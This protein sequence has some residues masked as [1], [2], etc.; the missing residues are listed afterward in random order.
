M[1]HLENAGLPGRLPLCQRDWH[2]H[3][4]RVVKEDPEAHPENTVRDGRLYHHILHWLDFNDTNPGD[5]W[6]LRIPRFE[7]GNVLRE[8]HDEPRAGHLGSAETLVRLARQYYLG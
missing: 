8:A 7:Q 1:R 6:K 2:H 5:Q 3:Q 4:K